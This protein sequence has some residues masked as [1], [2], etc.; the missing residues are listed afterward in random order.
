[1]KQP[2]FMLTYALMF[3]DNGCLVDGEEYANLD[4]VRDVAFEVSAETNRRV[5]ICE[6]FGISENVIETVLA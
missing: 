1:M 6:Y 3:S 4:E 5:A 2:T